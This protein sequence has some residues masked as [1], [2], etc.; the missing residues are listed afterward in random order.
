MELFNSRETQEKLGVSYD[1]LYHASVRLGIGKPIRADSGVGPCLWDDQ[2]VAELDEYFK[3]VQ[4]MKDRQPKSYGDQVIAKQ[5]EAAV[6]RAIKVADILVERRI[7][8]VEN[9]VKNLNMMGDP[10]KRLEQLNEAQAELTKL[11][12]KLN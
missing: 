7:A 1:R 8:Q 10:T 4:R 5:S 9:R 2:A 12:A 3:A 6:K 11:R